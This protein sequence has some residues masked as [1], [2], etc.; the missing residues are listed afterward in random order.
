MRMLEHEQKLDELRQRNMMKEA[1]QLEK[2]MQM[3]AMINKK[4]REAE[5][6]KFAQEKERIAKAKAEEEAN[7]KRKQE[8]FLQVRDKSLI[9]PIGARKVK[10]RTR[11]GN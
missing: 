9:N 11:E 10:E 4:R 3:E 8:L 6:K 1:A 7:K 5:E 2:K